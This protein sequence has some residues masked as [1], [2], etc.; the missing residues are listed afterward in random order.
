MPKLDTLHEK[1]KNACEKS[2]GEMLKL[3]N[4]RSNEIPDT[5]SVWLPD[6]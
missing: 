1:Y 3:Y 4:S 5:V 6:L 2:F